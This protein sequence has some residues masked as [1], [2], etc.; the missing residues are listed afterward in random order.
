MSLKYLSQKIAQTIDEELMS[1]AGGFSVDQLMELAGLSVAQAIAKVYDKSSHSRVLIC[2]GPGNNGGDGL[3]AARHLSHFGY[4]PNIFY[5][6]KSTKE[7]FQRLV[8]QCKNLKIP[9][10]INLDEQLLN[11]DLVVD[12]IFGFSFTGQIRTPFDEVIRKLKETKLPIASVDIPSAWDVEKGNID[13]CGFTP[14][15]LISLTAPK[16]GV[17]QFTGKHFLGGRFVS[18]EFAKKYELNLPQYPGIEQIVDITDL[19]KG[20]L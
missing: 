18:P 3:V 9:F 19:S 17:N 4:K 20:K 8:T 10:S 1:Q 6:K 14:S 5:P 2:C 13:N 15:M 11:N 12:A 7:L 16:L